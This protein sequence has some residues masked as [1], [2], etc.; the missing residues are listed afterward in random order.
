MLLA[1]TVVVLIPVLLLLAIHVVLVAK[2][3]TT[4]EMVRALRP[5]ALARLTRR[6][7]G[8]QIEQRFEDIQSPYS[9]GC[10][11]NLALVVADPRWPTY[12]TLVDTVR[13]GVCTSPA[14]ATVDGHGGPASAAGRSVPRAG[15][16]LREGEC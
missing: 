13:C 12:M 15:F 5:H 16:G 11:M 9:R 6:P 4:H 1:I 8:V 7:V 10:L 3:M 14:P 2:G